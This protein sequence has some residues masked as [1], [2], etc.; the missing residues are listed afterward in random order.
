M[1]EQQ[2]M[3]TIRASG[4]TSIHP[5]MVSALK[6]IGVTGDQVVQGYGY[7]SASAGFH[8]VH[9]NLPKSILGATKKTATDNRDFVSDSCFIEIGFTATGVAARAFLSTGV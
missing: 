9:Q 5:L 7:A 2:E 8:S 1:T 3:E 6:N 4:W